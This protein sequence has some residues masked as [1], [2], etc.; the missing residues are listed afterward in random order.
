MVSRGGEQLERVIWGDGGVL[1][2]DFGGG[3]LN[4][5]TPQNSQN[6][7]RKGVNFLYVN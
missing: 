3:H 1:N 5:H 6:H 4:P 7:T 2:P